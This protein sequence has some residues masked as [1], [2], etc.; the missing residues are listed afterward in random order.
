[1]EHLEAV[2]LGMLYWLGSWHRPWLNV[3]AMTL[4]H[5]GDRVVLLA[6]TLAGAALFLWLRQGRLAGVL[7]LVS[8]LSWGL[9]WAGKLAVARPRPDVVWHL[10]DVPEDSSFPSGH[11]LGS[12]AV[13]G[14][15][16]LL[17]GRLVARRR[18]REV[19]VLA[20]VGLAVLVGLTRPYL[21][22][23]YPLD[24]LA[25]W[26]G[27]LLCVGLAQALAGEAPPGSGGL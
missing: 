7:V 19:L 8:L 9:E 22:V 21:G 25:G 16:G 10:I 20:G 2:D 12:L 27:G 6:V 23:H 14:S 13:Y 24:V 3:L 18:L 15:L 1:M 26:V 4:T 11:A 17:G 5:L